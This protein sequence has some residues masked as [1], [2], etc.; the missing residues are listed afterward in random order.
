MDAMILAAGRGTRLIPITDEVPKALV[1]VDGVPMLERVARRLVDAG[2]RRI[3]VNVHHLGDQVVRFIEER[4]GFGAEVVISDESD[5]LLDTGGGLYHARE[6]FAGDEPILLHN[7]D[8]LSDIDLAALVDRHRSSDALASLAVMER[9]ATRHL[10]F[11]DVGL[12]GH[13]NAATGSDRMAREPRTAVRR[14]GF[15]GIH[16]L[17]PTIFN[18]ITERGV[19]SIIDVYMRLAAEGEPIV[20]ID[21]N[22]AFWMDIGT[23]RQLEE[24]RRCVRE[25]VI[26]L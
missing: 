9:E 3:V 12:V 1:D 15:C 25:G 20:P 10:L 22:G 4:E 6:A 5:M 8:V 2:A 7:V 17:S 19:F 23:H 18:R 11:D 24:A 16:V 14:M 13:G 21:V 26:Q